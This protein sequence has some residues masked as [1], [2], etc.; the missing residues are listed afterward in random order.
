[1]KISRKKMQRFSTPRC[2]SYLLFSLLVFSVHNNPVDAQ[3]NFDECGIFE[4]D[5][6]GTCLLFY[7]EDATLGAFYVDMGAITLPPPGTEGLLSGTEVDCFGICFPT[8]CIIGATFNATG[9]NTTPGPQFIR[10]DCNNDMT[11]NLAD[12]IYHLTSLFSSGPPPP[13]HAACDMD[14]DDGSNIADSIAMLN[15]LFLNAPPPPDPYPSYGENPNPS[16]FLDCLN[17]SCP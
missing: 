11:Y 4:M 5:P 14:L 6:L 8:S 9:C 12:P 10:G 15:L 2:I 7:P 3:S 1:M 13:C 17:P 16:Q